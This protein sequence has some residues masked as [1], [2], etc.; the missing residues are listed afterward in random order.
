M[1]DYRFG[2]AYRRSHIYPNGPIPRCG[3]LPAGAGPVDDRQGNDTFGNSLGGGSIFV[4]HDWQGLCAAFS[5]NH[6]LDAW[7]VGDH[8][9]PID[10]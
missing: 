6:L 1:V 7:H 3:P 5:P 9:K 10:R 4:G 2:A 8:G